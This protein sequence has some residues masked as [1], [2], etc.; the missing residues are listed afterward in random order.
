MIVSIL[1][2]R[3]WEKMISIIDNPSLAEAG[4]QRM[5]WF[6][7]QMPLIASLKESYRTE[8][9]F[10]GLKVAI[11][12]HVEPKTAF[13]IEAILAGGAEHVYLVGCLGTTKPDTA[14][15]LASNP[16]ITVFAKEKDAMEDHQR[17]LEMVIEEKPDLLLDNGASL[18]L[19]YHKKKRDWI[20]L[21]ANEETRTGRLLID[22]SGYDIAFP[23]VVIDDSPLKK[24]LENAVGV[25]Q[26]VVDGF[27]R[28][29][30]LLLGGKRILVIGYGWCGSGIA[31]KFRAMGAHT[32]VYDIDPVYLLKAK[33]DGHH[34]SENLNELIARADAIVTS[35]GRFHIITTE[36]IPYFSDGLILSNAGHFGFEIDVDELRAAASRVDVIGCGKET[37]WFGSRKVFLL[38]NAN[39]LNLAAG[40][41]NPIAIM[42]L[43]LGLQA[44]CG[45]LLAS[46]RHGLHKGVQPIPVEI[47]RAVSRRMLRF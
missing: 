18:I 33:V 30:S 41:G 14:A 45:A 36:H 8:L 25:G 20:P 46:G 15:F 19:A 1:T 2:E 22:S 35:T 42:D 31:G 13:W 16:K 26:S 37:L 9:P 12:L 47:D 5:N 39:P 10:R 21:G 43:G 17:Y 38:E 29:T 3:I 27:M 32:S 11:C 24:L 23:V 44:S 28:A 34:V 7:E 40:D 6:V 4:R